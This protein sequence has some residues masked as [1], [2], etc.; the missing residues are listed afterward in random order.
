MGVGLGLPA[1]LHKRLRR[2]GLSGA[3]SLDSLM[4]RWAGFRVLRLGFRVG[5][6]GLGLGLR[7]ECKGVDWS[8]LRH[9]SLMDRW[10]VFRV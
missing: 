7:A 9:W 8:E 1:Q 6:Q 10:A 2:G 3:A 4:D 5:V